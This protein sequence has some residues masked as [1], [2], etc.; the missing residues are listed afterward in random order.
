MPP[1][2]A[3]PP[4][5]ASPCPNLLAVEGSAAAADRSRW[6]NTTHSSRPGCGLDPCRSPS[7]LVARRSSCS[8]I[9]QA[10]CRDLICMSTGV[11]SD[12][13]SL[14]Y[15]G[16]DIGGGA[17][18]LGGVPAPS[19]MVFSHSDP[20][21]SPYYNIELKEIHVAGKALRVDSRIFD[22]KHGTVLDSGTTYAYLPEQAFVAFRDAKLSHF[23]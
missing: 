15:G 6:L 1:W 12:S 22:S 10:V 2:L 19:D 14:C 7:D 13:F 17:M 16:M 23:E 8:S 21:R 4:A 20:L 5:A 11:L 9:P 3:P 18:V